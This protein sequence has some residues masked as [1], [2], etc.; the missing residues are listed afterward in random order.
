MNAGLVSKPVSARKLRGLPLEV[1]P[2]EAGA[3][4][5]EWRLTRRASLMLTLLLSLGSWAAIWALVSALLR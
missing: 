4:G 2:S 1:Q 5:A 3:A